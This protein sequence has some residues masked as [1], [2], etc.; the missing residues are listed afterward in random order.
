MVF[1]WF[2]LLVSIASFLAFTAWTL[3]KDL[4]RVLS[5]LLLAS[6]TFSRY[7]I[8][9]SLACSTCLARS[10]CIFR[11]SFA[12]IASFFGLSHKKR[13]NMQRPINSRFA[14]FLMKVRAFF[15]NI[16]LIY[17]KISYLFIWW[18]GLSVLYLYQQRR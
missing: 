12:D 2:I 3:S 7:C 15:R 11:Y 14:C 13:N 17:F 5:C 8:C 9:V 4:L 10:W 1:S 18:F 16:F 6:T